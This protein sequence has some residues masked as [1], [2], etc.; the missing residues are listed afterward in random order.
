M[1]VRLVGCS[2]QA[3]LLEGPAAKL[4]ARDSTF[5]N[6]G[7]SSTEAQGVVIS[8]RRAAVHLTGVV[9]TD[10]RGLQQQPLLAA[11]RGPGALHHSA[12]NLGMG[13]PVGDPAAAATTG[14]SCRKL[15]STLQSS[16]IHLQQSNMT[17][18]RTRIS[19][20]TAGAA[21]VAEGSAAH[22]VLITQG[23]HLDGN[24]VTWLVVADALGYDKVGRAN[25]MAQ[26]A[27][28]TKSSS[29]RAAFSMYDFVGRA[30][31]LKKNQLKTAAQLLDVER[32]V[33]R[34]PADQVSRSYGVHTT[35]HSMPSQ[36]CLSATNW[37]HT[38]VD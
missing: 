8:A 36:Q 1:N 11:D 13:A 15:D 9:I 16:V 21:I 23:S 7:S 37:L 35:P 31:T 24:N 38:C 4:V 12:C 30:R 33:G 17:L 20:N 10:N 28:S 34:A 5:S 22:A 27:P 25:L 14:A 2:H 32:F 6:H 19:N 29:F 18:D 26:Q 3:V